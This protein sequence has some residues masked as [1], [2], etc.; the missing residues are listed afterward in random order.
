MKHVIVIGGGVAGLKCAAELARGGVKV[1]LLEKDE[2]AGGKLLGWHRLF[3]T[4]TPASEVLEPLLGEIGSSDM[5]TLR[6]GCE[7]AGVTAQSVKLASG[8]ELACDAV[9]IATGFTLFDAKV[10]EEYG[11]GLYDNVVTSADLE[12]MF[13]E[14]EVKLHNGRRPERIAILHCVGSRDEKVCQ[15]HCSKV[16][17]V[18]GVKQAIELK[19]L[20]PQSEIFNF[21]M[22]LR[23]FGPG[24]E[25]MYRE[26]QRE[27]NIH[28]VRGRISEV[29]PMMNSR[30]Q[31]KAEDTLTGRPLKIG[32]DLL[33][34][35][36]GMKANDSNAVL[37]ACVGG[38]QMQPS[39]F[40]QPL[41]PFG[42]N[43]CSHADGIFY[44]GAV[45][46]PKNVCESLGDSAAAA[47][48]VLRRLSDKQ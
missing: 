28:F 44:A 13:A 5:I 24:Y 15:R 23:M 7:A 46:A 40:M 26:A 37:A 41:D 33:V 19:R 2:R 38:L 31:I 20:F 6:T 30:L 35:M 36:V 16:C 42:G 8:E 1:T 45:T 22:D 25:E 32:V 39:G 21:Y 4:F 18:T 17:C 9:V 10:K 34:L 12:R 29:S 43:V 14:G 11:Y 3:P 48:A 27:Y 47:C